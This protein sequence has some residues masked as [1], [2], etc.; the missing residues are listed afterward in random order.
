MSIFAVIQ[1]LAAAKTVVKSKAAGPAEKKG[2]AA[3]QSAK[4]DYGAAVLDALRNMNAKSKTQ[5]LTNVKVPGSI[6]PVSYN[7]M[8]VFFGEFI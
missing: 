1:L 3:T 7:S 4:V 2:T 5:A 6:N 8:F